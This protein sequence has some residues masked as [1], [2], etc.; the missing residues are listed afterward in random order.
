[1]IFLKPYLGNRALQGTFFV[2]QF[3]YQ[4]GNNKRG[5]V[6]LHDNKI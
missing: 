3:Y 2:V 6:M 4:N 5:R 1:M